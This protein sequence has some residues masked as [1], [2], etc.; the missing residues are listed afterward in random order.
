MN[1]TNAS[2]ARE[3]AES[4]NREG[5]L[6]VGRIERAI[7]DQVVCANL[8]RRGMWPTESGHWDAVNVLAAYLA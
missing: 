8:C 2:Q 5:R 6:T 7:A 3:W 4:W 1:V